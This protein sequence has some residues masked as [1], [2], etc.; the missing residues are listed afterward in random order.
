MSMP[1]LRSMPIYKPLSTGKPAPSQPE[2]PADMTRTSRQP[3]CFARR[4]AFGAFRHGG[5]EQ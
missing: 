3:S 1:P 4:A 5:F 2:L